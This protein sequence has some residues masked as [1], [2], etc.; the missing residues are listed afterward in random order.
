MAK[1]EKPGSTMWGGCEAIGTPM[2]PV[3]AQIVT[4]KLENY[5]ALSTTTEQS[6]TL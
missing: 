4:G 6:H 2:L 1:I 5:F 3:G